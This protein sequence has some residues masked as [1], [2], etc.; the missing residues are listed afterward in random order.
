MTFYSPPKVTRDPIAPGTISFC[1]DSTA[2]IDSMAVK[3]G[4]NHW[5]PLEA[6][7][8]KKR[9]QA[10]WQMPTLQPC[11]VFL[12]VFHGHPF[13]ADTCSSLICEASFNWG[14]CLKVAVA[15]P[16]WRVLLRPEMDYT[17]VYGCFWQF[18]AGT[19]ISWNHG[20]EEFGQRR[21][22]DSPEDSL[23]RFPLDFVISGSQ[24]HGISEDLFFRK[25]TTS[26]WVISGI[27]VWVNISLG[28]IYPLKFP[29]LVGYIIYP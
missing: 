17:T 28:T 16:R 25:L 12:C 11:G 2:W 21:A 13:A 29:Y 6:L 1:S 3:L 24:T 5:E 9:N 26:S 18:W 22:R 7:G 23:K 19:I 15:R 27:D 4:C 20:V 14:Y 8:I 10:P